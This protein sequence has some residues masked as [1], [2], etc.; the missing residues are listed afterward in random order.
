MKTRHAPHLHPEP[1]AHSGREWHLRWVNGR[2]ILV[3]V[4]LAEKLDITDRINAIRR[5]VA[6][7]CRRRWGDGQLNSGDLGLEWCRRQPAAAHK[8]A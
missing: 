2:K 1:V 4:D 3:G 7:E 8:P 6:A 5:A